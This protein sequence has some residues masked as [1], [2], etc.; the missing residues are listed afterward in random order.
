IHERFL[1]NAAE[2]AR[3]VPLMPASFKAQVEPDVRA[4]LQQLPKM[5]SANP[6][7]VPISEGGWAGDGL[8]VAAANA[9]Y[10]LHKVFPE[11]IG[12]D[13]VFRSLDYLYGTH[14]GSNVSF[15]S[16]VGSVSKEV[17]YGNNRADFTFIAG[18]VVPG[19]LIIKPDF[20]ENRE[21]WPFFWG[22]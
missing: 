5:T 4:L 14:P 15:V 9:E 18:G 8:V 3:A 10:Q 21:D 13:L 19:A 1:F 22:E 6:F 16:G 17:A 7:G 11:I 2:V 20:P 12:D